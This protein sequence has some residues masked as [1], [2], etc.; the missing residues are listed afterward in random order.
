M[1]QQ[2]PF[3]FLFVLFSTTLAAQQPRSVGHGPSPT[4]P[5]PTFELL[6]PPSVPLVASPD[7]AVTEKYPLEPFY[8]RET[9]NLVPTGTEDQSAF[10]AVRELFEDL[11]TLLEEHAIFIRSI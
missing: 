6:L 11:S 4:D 7:A 3:V 9:V 8:Q 5:R 1:S 2:L 10:H